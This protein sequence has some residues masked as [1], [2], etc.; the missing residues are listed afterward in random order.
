MMEDPEATSPLP[1]VHWVAV[2]PSTVTELPEAVPPLERHARFPG[3]SQ[4]SNSRSTIGYFGP[5]PPAGSPP[6]PYY[7]QV[8]ALDTVP[9]LPGA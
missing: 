9:E 1:F 5:R 6:Y 2:L 4:G 7:F 8:F 3:A